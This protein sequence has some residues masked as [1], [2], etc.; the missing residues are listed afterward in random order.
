MASEV[1]IANEAL[2]LL[3]AARITSLTEDSVNAREVNVCYTELRDRELEKHRWRFATARTVLAPDA[4]APA[5][6]FDYAF[7][8][9]TDCLAVRMPARP[10]LDWQIENHND[11]VSILTNEGDSIDLIYVKRVTDPN[12]MVPTFRGAL[13]AMIAWV[14]CEK[15]TQSN[16]KK[17]D[18]KDF[19]AVQIASARKSNAIQRLADEAP[20]SSWVTARTGGESVAPWLTW[21]A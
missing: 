10:N 6:D 5:F 1:S 3:G 14:K 2:D 11:V 9:P 8:L 7:P 12:V 4:T 18:A 19:Y 13:A 16:S 21:G 17:A 15:I 20:D